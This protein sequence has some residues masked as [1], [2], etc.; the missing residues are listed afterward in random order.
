MGFRLEFVI[1]RNT[2]KTI[3]LSLLVC[4]LLGTSPGFA[5][6]EETS[7]VGFDLY[8]VWAADSDVAYAVGFGGLIL[9]RTGGT[10]SQMNSNT[11]LSLFDV[12]GSNQDDVWAVGVGGITLH[13]DGT[14]WSV[15]E[16]G[17]S[18]SLVAVEGYN[19][20]HIY[21]AGST[22]R[23]VY[24]QWN[25]TSSAMDDSFHW[26]LWDTG[27]GSG[28]TVFTV[29]AISVGG[30]GDVWL[31]GRVSDTDANAVM[32]HWN[33]N[34]WVSYADNSGRR[35]NDIDGTASN[36][37]VVGLDNFVQ[38]FNG[39]IWT[40]VSPLGFTETPWR[41]VVICSDGVY[42]CGDRGLILH[43]DHSNW[44][45]D[46]N[47][48]DSVQGFNKIHSAGSSIWAVGLNGKIYK[49]TVSTPQIKKADIVRDGIVDLNDI[50]E[51]SS[52]WL[53]VAP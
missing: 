41:S 22:R 2:V 43:W 13:W 25:P 32:Q 3:I 30:R 10:W 28:Q 33:G 39:T 6:Q 47:L 9:K 24:L 20:S 18:A 17:T 23:N 19:S 4:L 26:M 34:T 31:A 36:A 48:D 5:W 8:G 52:Q 53:T 1:E 45:T 27:S 37:V 16:S 29:D 38:Y 11:T 40:D 49:S 7:P 50:A 46:V 42:I 12:W 51:F 44:I 15:V 35:I 14:N 21:S